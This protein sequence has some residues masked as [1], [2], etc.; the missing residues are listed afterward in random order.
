MDIM[1]R[2]LIV[3]DEALSRSILNS[4]FSEFAACD[5][6]ENGFEAL[7]LFK[8]AILDGNPY[9]LICTDLVMPVLDGYELITK[10][11]ESEEAL[12]I[13]DY[14]RTKIFVISV[15]DSN[16]D[17]AHALLECDCDDYIVKPFHRDQLKSL[18]EKYS[19]L[20]SGH[21]IP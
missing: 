6:A 13:K 9:D 1:K 15:S 12:P 8:N 11:R 4:F 7:A 16:V 17:M 19:L 2:F 20:E 10:V 18:L 5:T 14:M 3:E 21:N